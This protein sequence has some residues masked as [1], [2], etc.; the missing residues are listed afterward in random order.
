MKSRKESQPRE[1]SAGCIFKNPEGDHAGRLIDVC[2]LKGHSRGGAMV[3]T[4]HANFIVNTGAATAAD[5]LGLI[6]EV[7]AS[8]K[9]ETGVLLEP[10]AVLLGNEWKEVLAG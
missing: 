6:N 2:G 7:R 4:I 1:A 5:V 3:S 9:A 10:E 8:V